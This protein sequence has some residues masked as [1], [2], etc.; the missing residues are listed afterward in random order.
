VFYAF[1]GEFIGES[2]IGVEMNNSMIYR[3]KYWE[4]IADKLS[5][6]G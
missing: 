1:P 5:K 4:S 3:V 2:R 6:G